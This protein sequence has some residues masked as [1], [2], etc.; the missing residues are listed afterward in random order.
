MET[1]NKPRKS[2][3]ALVIM[4]LMSG[5]ANLVGLLSAISSGSGK[6]ESI[7]IENAVSFY[8]ENITA[9]VRDWLHDLIAVISQHFAI[10][11][12]W[13]PV[14]LPE[15]LPFSAVFSASLI[16]SYCYI[17]NIT[18]WSLS[19]VLFAMLKEFLTSLVKEPI[20]TIFSLIPRSFSL[21]LCVIFYSA[22]FLLILLFSP[23]FLTTLILV[24]GGVFVGSVLVS[25]LIYLGVGI[26]FTLVYAALYLVYVLM[27]VMKDP[28]QLFAYVL[29]SPRSVIN[30][31]V[32]NQ[33]CWADVGLSFRTSFFSRVLFVLLMVF[34]LYVQFRMLFQFAKD[35]ASAIFIRSWPDF[36][37][38]DLFPILFIVGFVLYIVYYIESRKQTEYARNVAIA[39]KP[40]FIFR[41]E[42]MPKDVLNLGEF[43]LN[44]L[45]IIYSNPL[46]NETL[47]SAF[48]LSKQLFFLLKLIFLQYFFGVILLM[49]A[50]ALYIYYGS[51]SLK[52]L[53]DAGQEIYVNILSFFMNILSGLKGII[54]D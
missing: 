30:F 6:W 51:G 14:W 9:R 16:Y 29:S 50:I 47:S 19:L 4:F 5:I 10:E 46:K 45:R 22:L 43:S 11:L 40:Y 53:M 3:I 8:E 13:L 2:I 54:F 39:N 17:N 44:H 21:I 31:V 27:W 34:L 7:Y 52:E 20:A 37:Q 26:Y 36:E 48:S 33:I 38:A 12:T 18:A 25:G 23:I 24:L 32:N 41:V 35:A 28:K 1:I 42:T 49:V 15:Y